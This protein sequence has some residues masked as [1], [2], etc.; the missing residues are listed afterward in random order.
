MAFVSRTLQSSNLR[1]QPLFSS[2]KAAESL[3]AGRDT[4]TPLGKESGRGFSFFIE[5]HLIT[6]LLYIPFIKFRKKASTPA[7]CCMGLY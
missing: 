7:S 3:L 1:Q 6:E 5:Y 2:H 4:W